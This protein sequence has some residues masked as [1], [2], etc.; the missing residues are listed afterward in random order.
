MDLEYWLK[1]WSKQIRG[2]FT[3]LVLDNADGII[4]T[5]DDQALLFDTLSAMRRL[6]DNY[7]TFVIISRTRL[8]DQQTC[9]EVKLRPLSQEDARSILNSCVNNE[10]GKIQLDSSDLDAVARLC[11]CSVGTLHRRST[12]VRLP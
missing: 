3:V 5:E 7:L 8:Q 1:N 2:Q 11:G 9:E 4:E 10:E 6:S 12:S